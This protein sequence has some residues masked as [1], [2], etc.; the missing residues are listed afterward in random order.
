MTGYEALFCPHCGGHVNEHELETD[1]PDPVHHDPN[2]GS[3]Y[4]CGWCGVRTRDWGHVLNCRAEH[5]DPVLRRMRHNER[6]RDLSALLHEV[7]TET[8]WLVNCETCSWSDD[9][10]DD[11]NAALALGRLH[12]AKHLDAGDDYEFRVRKYVKPSKVMSG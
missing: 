1:H 12:A 7:K 8:T 5:T 2:M 11:R 9:T 4:T 10:M 3:A 6:A